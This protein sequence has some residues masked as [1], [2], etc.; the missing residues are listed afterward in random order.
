[1]ATSKILHVED[2]EMYQT[3]VRDMLGEEGYD[4]R[5]GGHRGRGLPDA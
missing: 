1:M 4:G 3:L 2:E 5:G